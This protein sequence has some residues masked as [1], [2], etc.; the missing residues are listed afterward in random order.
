MRSIISGKVKA[1]ISKTVA[2][3]ADGLEAVVA[4]VIKARQEAILARAK[5]QWPVE[6]GRSREGLYVKETQQGAKVSTEIAYRM[7]YTLAVH[8]AGV[9]ITAW[10]EFVMGP[11]RA[12][13]ESTTKAVADAVI[14][15]L[16][17]W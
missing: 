17:R 15:K 6:T 2:K 14:A 7:P 13:A 1:T 5:L 8:R 11:V 3:A 16:R 10:E 12:D 4:K 9:S